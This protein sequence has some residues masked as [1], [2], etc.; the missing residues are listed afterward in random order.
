MKFLKY[1]NIQ[2]WLHEFATDNLSLDSL[3]DIVYRQ[4]YNLYQIKFIKK[5][6]VEIM[7]TS[8]TTNKIYKIKN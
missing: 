6:E 2:G 1:T 4:G 5:F 7:V 8:N 3:K